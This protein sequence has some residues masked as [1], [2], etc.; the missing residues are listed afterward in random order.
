[1]EFCN[2][3]YCRQS[4]NF[5]S[6]KMDK[7][8]IINNDKL[9]LGIPNQ[10]DNDGSNIA[11]YRG[12]GLSDMINSIVNQINPRCSLELSLHVLEAM[13]GILISAKNKEIYNLK[14]KPSQPRFLDENEIK[15]LKK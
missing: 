12:I 14:T 5:I 1:M 9:L 6:N 7:W 13:E 11:N 15:E 3:L 10:K 4:I 2:R 8:Q